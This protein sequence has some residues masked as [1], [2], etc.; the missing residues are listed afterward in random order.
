MVFTR[1][2]LIDNRWLGVLAIIL[3]IALGIAN[4][5]HFN[6]LILWSVILLYLCPNQVP[7][8]QLT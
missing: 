1:D 7:G 2:I 8:L 6:L 5:F 4:I 3:G